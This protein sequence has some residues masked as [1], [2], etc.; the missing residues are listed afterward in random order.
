[1][2][3]RPPCVSDCFVVHLASKSDDIPLL[4]RSAMIL[5]FG[6][7]GG[8]VIAHHTWDTHRATHHAEKNMSIYVHNDT[9]ASRWCRVVEFLWRVFSRLQTACELRELWMH[10][11]HLDVMAAHNRAHAAALEAEDK[12]EAVRHCA[13]FFFLAATAILSLV[14][15]TVIFLLT[16]G[17][18]SCRTPLRKACGTVLCC[19]PRLA[20]H[21]GTAD[22]DAC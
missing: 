20:P 12:C 3:F 18:Q 4:V 9:S 16:S 15:N 13:E 17:L 5:L 19:V 8:N 10:R 14:C 2:R 1:M 21:F 22:V 11:Q 6:L 7:C